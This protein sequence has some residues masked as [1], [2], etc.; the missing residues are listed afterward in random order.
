MVRHGGPVPRVLGPASLAIRVSLSLLRVGG[1]L[2]DETSADALPEMRTP[3]VRDGR[4]DLSQDTPAASDVVPDDVV[5]DGPEERG[6]R[7][8]TSTDSW[9][10]QL[11]DGMGLAPQIAVCHGPA[12]KGLVDRRG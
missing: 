11:P 6:Q 3:S 9:I 7:P 5:G 12:R 8:W 2:A 1:G 4:H 10:G